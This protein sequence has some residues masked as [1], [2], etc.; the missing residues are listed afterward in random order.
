VDD[1][2]DDQEIFEM[3]LQKVD[4]NMYLIV[5]NDGVEAIQTLKGDPSFVPDFIFL[6]INMP[7]MGG[8]QCL[9]EIKKLE[10]LNPAK[11]VLYSTAIND[12]IQRS[13]RELGADEILVKPTK[14]A[15]LI[16]NLT[17]ILETKNV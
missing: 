14:I 12:T 15:V 16:N 4:E 6:D 8:M 7:K 5:A 10:H 2:I 11:I 1:D 9:P 17:R 3:A 13:S